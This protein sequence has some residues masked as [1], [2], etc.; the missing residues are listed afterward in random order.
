MDRKRTVEQVLFRPLR[1]G[2]FEWTTDS[3]YPTLKGINNIFNYKAKGRG[4]EWV[5]FAPENTDKGDIYRVVDGKSDFTIR[6]HKE[7]V[8][9]ES[10]KTRDLSLPSSI[11]TVSPLTLDKHESPVEEIIEL[12]DH[13]LRTGKCQEHLRVPFCTG[14]PCFGR[15]LPSNKCNGT[16]LYGEGELVPTVRGDGNTF[17]KDVSD[18]IKLRPPSDSEEQDCP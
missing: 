17:R 18:I 12:A 4:V 16:G 15:M 11:Q 2:L 9:I 13:Y 6:I 14:S 10:L 1:A 5:I 7:Q 3:C 8:V